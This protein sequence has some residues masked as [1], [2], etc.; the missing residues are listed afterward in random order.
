MDLLDISVWASNRVRTIE[1]SPVFA[2][3][4]FRLKVREFVPL[5]GDLIE[6]VWSDEKG[7]IRTHDIPPY[8]IAN[9]EE[10]ARSFEEYVD[11]AISKYII[12]AVGNLDSLLWSTYRMAFKHSTE[13]KVSQRIVL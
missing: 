3:A 1:V 11:R 12:A 2:D 7:M 6:E 9:M 8:A 10:S 4:P 13:A 5:E